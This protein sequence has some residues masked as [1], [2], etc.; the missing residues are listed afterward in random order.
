MNKLMF[1]VGTPQANGTGRTACVFFRPSQAG[2]KE[3]LK[4]QYGNGCSAHVSKA[5]EKLRKLSS[6]HSGRI[7]YKLSKNTH[8]TT[9]WMFP[10]WYYS[11]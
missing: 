8:L 1:D 4:V 11:T 6:L 9:K 5:K 3:I 10:Q 2:D 7:W